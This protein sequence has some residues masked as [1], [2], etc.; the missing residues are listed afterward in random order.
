MGEFPTRRYV[1][2]FVVVFL[3]FW[4]NLKRLSVEREDENKDE[5]VSV[6]AQIEKMDDECESENREEEK[7]ITREENV[8]FGGDG[9]SVIIIFF[10]FFS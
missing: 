4:G 9:F 6:V 7:N 5:F 3:L 10:F 1:H 2:S 8:R